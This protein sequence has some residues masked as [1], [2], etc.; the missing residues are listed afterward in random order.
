MSNK[1][2]FLTQSQASPQFFL[3]YLT[4]AEFVIRRWS[5]TSKFTLKIHN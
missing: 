1:T 5:V 3:E 4:N 2:P